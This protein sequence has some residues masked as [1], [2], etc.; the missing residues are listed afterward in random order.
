MLGASIVTFASLDISEMTYILITRSKILK[1]SMYP[2]VFQSL[3]LLTLWPLKHR[4]QRSTINTSA[5]CQVGVAQGFIRGPA[6]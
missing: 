1:S 5:D 3:P 6:R 2:L 4:A